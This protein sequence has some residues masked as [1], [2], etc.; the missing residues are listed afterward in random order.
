MGKLAL[1]AKVTHVPSMYLSELPGPRQGTRQD[2]IDGHGNSN[3]MLLM[4]CGS[5]LL[6]YRPLKWAPQLMW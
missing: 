6:V 1:A 5:S 3:A 2:A 4:K